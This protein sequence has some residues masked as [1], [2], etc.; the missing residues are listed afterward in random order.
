M[1][2][3]QEATF[4]IYNQADITTRPGNDYP[5]RDDFLLTVPYG[6]VKVS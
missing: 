1:Y 4:F 6:V 3:W 2:I 5:G